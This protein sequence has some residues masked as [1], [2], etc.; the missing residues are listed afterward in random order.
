MGWPEER[1]QFEQRKN[2]INTYLSGD[3]DKDVA[4]FNEYAGA[5]VISGGMTGTPVPHT[6]RGQQLDGDTILMKLY[7]SYTR[8]KQKYKETDNLKDDIA[9]YLLGVSNTSDVQ[10]KLR[11]IGSLQ[12]EVLNLE[13]VAKKAESEDTAAADRQKAIKER[14]EKISFPQMFSGIAKPFEKR[15]YQWLFPL[16]LA[17]F[18]VGVF[19]MW[20]G[21]KSMIS[22]P[23]SVLGAA[24]NIEMPFYKKPAFV[25]TI[26][27]LMTGS[28]IVTF[29]VA[30]GVIR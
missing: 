24:T 1:R 2:A 28:I 15:T 9:N 8:I 21:I 7:E 26:L 30:F 22:L 18:V 13:D 12:Q 11:E 17:L 10:T 6:V 25:L 14:N 3:Y 5:F 29:L 23:A 27:A 19:L 16:G 20:P 4:N